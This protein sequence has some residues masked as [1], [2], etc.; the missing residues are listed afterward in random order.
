M[1]ASPVTRILFA[2]VWLVNG[3][4]CKM[5]DGVPRHREIVA[6]ILGE[7]HSLLLTRLIGVGEVLMAVWILT[8]IRW[9]W[10]CAAQIAA[11]LAMNVI[12]FIVV[13]DLLL[14]GRFNSLVALAY[15]MVVA[16]AGFRPGKR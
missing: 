16:W 8:G 12:E 4:W 2:A 1:K 13:P 5:M 7:E 11:V 10:N 15:I 9:K 6:R 3:I 14:F